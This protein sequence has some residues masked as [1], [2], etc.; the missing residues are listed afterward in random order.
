[1]P[2]RA[3]V[4]EPALEAPDAVAKIVT[5]PVSISEISPALHEDFAKRLGVSVDDAP[6][7]IVDRDRV[8]G[9]LEKASVPCL[10]LLETLIG[11]GGQ[12]SKETLFALLLTRFGWDAATSMR[13]LQEAIDTSL[14]VYAGIGRVGSRETAWYAVVLAESAEQ[15]ADATWGLSLPKL[16]ASL[17]TKAPQRRAASD[18]FQRDRIGRLAALAHFGVRANKGGTAANRA[19][20]KKLALVVKQSEDAL[21]EEIAEGL[22]TQVLRTEGDLIVPDREKL[23]SLADG[24][25]VWGDVSEGLDA[26]IPSDRWVSQESVVRACVLARRAPRGTPIWARPWDYFAHGPIELDH[27]EAALAH[28]AAHRVVVE[29]QTFLRRPAPRPSAGDGHVTPSMEVMLGPAATLDVTMKIALMA[30]PLRFDNVLT[31]KLTPTSISAAVAQGLD[32]T[33]MLE[34]LALV[35][36]H[37]TP[38]NVRAMIE[39]WARSARSARIRAV[40]SIE[41]SSAE[42]ADVVARAL[43]NRVVA[44][45]LPTLL[46][47]DH[48]LTA[49]EVALAKLGV[50]STLAASRA[51]ASDASRSS[52]PHPAR[53]KRP[54]PAWLAKVEAARSEGIR[55]EARPKTAN[56]S[57]GAVSVEDDNEHV[58]DPF[59]QLRVRGEASADEA[60]RTFYFLA[61]DLLEAASPELA[62]WMVELEPSTG[63][64]TFT[65]I[66]DLPLALLSFAALTAQRRA[67]VLRDHNTLASL[68][69]ASDVQIRALTNCST[70]GQR[71]LSALTHPQVRALVD[72]DSRA[73]GAG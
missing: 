43:G 23:E 15:I 19:S 18:T 60:L 29:G 20:L 8:A 33:Q 38:E 69:Q 71:V 64:E 56:V 34:T 72:A 70:E 24:S 45:P 30:E 49:P 67:D 65:L 28:C 16:P 11:A 47:V 2:R 73:L 42:T 39:D 25:F 3:K 6:R 61:A 32:L 4:A 48:A 53:D 46:L 31:F 12:L 40:W 51:P 35:G 36:R 50:K 58:L 44:R 26:W 17:E 37:P 21:G 55:V 63:A 27:A 66:D 9:A 41:L 10:L 5:H 52:R 22:R 54:S 57:R 59:E 14:L 13:A 7:A 68:A 1:M 62:A